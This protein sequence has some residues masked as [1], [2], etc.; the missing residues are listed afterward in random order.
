MD[1]YNYIYLPPQRIAHYKYCSALCFYLIYFRDCPLSVRINS[2]ILLN[3]HQVFY[4]SLCSQVLTGETFGFF[5]LL[6][7]LLQKML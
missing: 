1:M 4:N 3:Y 7:Y 6:C 5:P 2:L